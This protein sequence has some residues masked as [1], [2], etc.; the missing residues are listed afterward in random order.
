[1]STRADERATAFESFGLKIG[2]TADD[3]AVIARLHDLGPVGSRP[4]NPEDAEC[5]IGVTT[6]DQGRFNV[7]FDVREGKVLEERDP[8][9]YI[10]GDSDLD[11]AIEA[12]DVHIQSYIALHAPDLIFVRAGVVGYRGYAILLPG[13]PISGKSTLVRALVDVGATAYSEDYAPLDQTGRVHPYVR[14]AQ[15]ETQRANGQPGAGAGDSAREL[16]PLPV[17]AIVL[18]VYRPG[19]EWRPESVSHGQAVLALVEHAEPGSE[20][21]EETFRGITN[22]LSGRPAALQSGRGEAA[23]VARVL[24]AD[25]ERARFEAA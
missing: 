24:L 20:R 19:A 1:M 5:L 3:P 7:R 16:E 13:G 8:T 2:V 15:V 11:L 12:L 21:P 14:S 4:C 18:T 6:T 9:A 25:V 22:A 23:A 17:G 10:A